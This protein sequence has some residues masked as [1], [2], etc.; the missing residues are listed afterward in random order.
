M[1]TT[2]RNAARRNAHT[3][4]EDAFGAVALLALLVGSLH[5]PLLF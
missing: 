1:M 2:L 5:L 3:L 4:A